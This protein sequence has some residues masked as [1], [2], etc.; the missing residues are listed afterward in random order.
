MLTGVVV[1][2]LGYLDNI[3]LHLSYMSKDLPLVYKFLFMIFLKTF[4]LVQFMDYLA[5]LCVCSC[6]SLDPNV[7]QLCTLKGIFVCS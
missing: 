7:T 5:S 3:I 1:L 6:S 4:C 2:I